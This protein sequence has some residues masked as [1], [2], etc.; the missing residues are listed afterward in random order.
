MNQEN[1][2][3]HE[4]EWYHLEK[5]YDINAMPSETWEQHCVHYN[6]CSICPMAIH[7]HLLSTTKHHC[8]RGLSEMEFRIIMSSADCEY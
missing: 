3:Y 6:D 4:P 2:T 5:F 7:Q 8:T 1:L